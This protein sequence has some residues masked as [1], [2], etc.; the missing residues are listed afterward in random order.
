MKYEIGKF[1]RVPCADYD[2]DGDGRCI[3]AIPVQG[4][5]HNDR[6]II[7]FAF[8]HYH[9]DPRFMSDGVLRRFFAGTF[10]MFVPL[11]AEALKYPL[12]LREEPHR[13]LITGETRLRRRKCYRVMPFFPAE[14][15]RWIPKL[16]A[17]YARCRLN[18][19]RPICP[20]RGI[21]LDGLPE[22]DGVVIC[23]GH[24]LQWNML[25]GE[26]VPRRA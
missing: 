18:L 26:L 12:P 20:H 17:M 22:R 10:P 23:P 14:A 15:F 2:L 24:G 7:G 19:A 13:S 4:P 1:Y 3:A 6:A 21:D 8:E 25:T 11:D 16:E 5:L 9:V